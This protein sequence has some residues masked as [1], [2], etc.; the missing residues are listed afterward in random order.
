MHLYVSLGYVRFLDHT[1][2]DIQMNVMDILSNWKEEALLPY[3]IHLRN[4]INVKVLREELIAWNLSKES[5]SIAESHREYLIPM[6]IRI[7]M[8]KVRKIKALTSRKVCLSWKVSFLLLLLTCLP[9]LHVCVHV[10]V[11]LILSE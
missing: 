10:H 11:D 4:L 3:D 1:D 6:V 9:W 2:S 8:P 5:H 7:L